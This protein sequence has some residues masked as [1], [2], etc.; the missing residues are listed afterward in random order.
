M[1]QP[2]TFAYGNLVFGAGPADAWAVYRLDTRSYAG[3]T[4]SA[5]RELLT[6]LA[7]LVYSLEADFS[8]LRVARPWSVDGYSAGVEMTVDPAE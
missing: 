1:K 8:L 2:I 4:K 7:S 3:L 5:K 6:V